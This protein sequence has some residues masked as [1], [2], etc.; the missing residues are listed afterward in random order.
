MGTITRQR[1]II[2]RRVLAE[3]LSLAARDARA[4]ALDRGPFLG[5]LKAA[6]AS[7]RVRSPTRSAPAR[8]YDAT[9]A[10]YPALFPRLRGRGS[11]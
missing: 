4:A 7:C 11:G 9:V 3:Q 8:R 6:L 1:D 5:A 2:D 10:L